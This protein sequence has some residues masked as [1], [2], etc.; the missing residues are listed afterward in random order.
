MKSLIV[1][2]YLGLEEINPSS[3]Q[4]KYVKSSQTVSTPHNGIHSI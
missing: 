4:Q 1:I 3:K 2:M